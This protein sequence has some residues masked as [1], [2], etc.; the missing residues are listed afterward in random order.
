MSP[1]GADAGLSEKPVAPGLPGSPREG[2][3]H[4]AS[5]KWLELGGL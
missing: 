4:G 1:A 2:L 5:E 3:G